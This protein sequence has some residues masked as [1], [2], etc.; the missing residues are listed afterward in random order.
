MKAK[1]S[2]PLAGW[3]GGSFVVPGGV[4]GW[5]V[6]GGR[7]WGHSLKCDGSNPHA[8]AALIVAVRNEARRQGFKEFRWQSFPEESLALTRLKKAR[9]EF[10]QMVMDV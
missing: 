7:F 9:I 2:G 4:V 5:D 8:A 1:E 6:R 3:G 10:V